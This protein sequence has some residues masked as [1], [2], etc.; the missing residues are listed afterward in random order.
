MIRID[1]DNATVKNKVSIYS[2][3]EVLCVQSDDQVLRYV[4]L[5]EIDQIWVDQ[6]T[7]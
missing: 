4:P 3:V 1:S 2:E 6:K 7:K 5:K